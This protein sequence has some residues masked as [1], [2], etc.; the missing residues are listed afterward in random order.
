MF[1][2]VTSVHY[3]NVLLKMVI[4]LSKRWGNERENVVAVV[5]QS[6]EKNYGYY[7]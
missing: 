5:G 2:S 6:A 3:K 7:Q 4:T 1:N